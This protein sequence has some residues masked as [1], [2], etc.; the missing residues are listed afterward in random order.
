MQYNYRYYTEIAAIYAEKRKMCFGFLF[1]QLILGG[2]FGNS[3]TKGSGN[4]ES[5]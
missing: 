5:C 4:L 3:G 2:V 1:F